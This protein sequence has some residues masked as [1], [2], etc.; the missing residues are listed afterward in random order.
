MELIPLSFFQIRFQPIVEAEARSSRRD[1]VELDRPEY[2]IDNSL[3]D[4]DYNDETNEI[5]VDIDETENVQNWAP[6][7]IEIRTLT[8]VE[9]PKDFNVEFVDYTMVKLSW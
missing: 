1:I 6:Y 8:V 2:D 5:S 3:T 4:T 9:A 7:W